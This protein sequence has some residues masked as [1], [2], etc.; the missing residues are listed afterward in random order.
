MVLESE[1]NG[2]TQLSPYFQL[3]GANNQETKMLTKTMAVLAAALI[4]GTASAAL[5]SQSGVDRGAVLPGNGGA[6]PVYHP[7]WFHGA[8]GAYAKHTHRISHP[9][10]QER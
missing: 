8:K 9:R 2:S 7:K 3:V 4:L 5:A 6:N 10:T 1:S